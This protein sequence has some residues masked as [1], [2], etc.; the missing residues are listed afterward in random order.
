[1]TKMHLI[2][3]GQLHTVAVHEPSG[4]TLHTDAPTDNQGKGE[5]F[6]PTDLLA[7]ALATCIA[8]VIGIYAKRKGWDLRSMRIDYEKTM[9]NNPRRIKSIALDVWFPIEISKDE[10]EKVKEIALTCPVHHSLHPSIDIPL[11]FHWKK[12]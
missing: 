7:T 11:T 2:Y 6:S 1:M 10:R 9:E 12:E 4:Q 3:E 8:T 5:T